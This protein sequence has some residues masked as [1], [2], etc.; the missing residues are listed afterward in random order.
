MTPGIT[1]LTATG[2]PAQTRL[3]L[4]FGRH[5]VPVELAGDGVT[6]RVTR[7]EGSLHY[8]REGAGRTV[9]AVV[10]AAAPRLIVNPVEPVNQPQPICSTFMLR[11]TKTLLLEPKGSCKVFVTFPI[12]VGVFVAARREV[13]MV[14]VF[15]LVPSKFAL[16]GPIGSGKVCRYW[17]SDLHHIPPV[18]NPLRQGIVELDVRNTTSRWVTVGRAVFNAYGMKL[19]F[20][21]DMVAMRAECKITG[22]DMAETHF[23]DEPLQEGMKKS[24]EVYR[25]R[26]LSITASKFIMEHGI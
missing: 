4:S 24:L 10:A 9:E 17:K 23:L 12:E 20:N 19:F 6:I 3:S 8:V 16:Y 11:L 13:E 18:T 5:H 15:S 1:S 25:L 21:S 14:D 26:R 2:E 7:Q 22:P